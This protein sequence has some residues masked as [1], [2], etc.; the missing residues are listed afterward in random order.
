M[1]VSP[2]PSRDWAVE[3]HRGGQ[4]TEAMAAYRT[5]LARDPDSPDLLGLLGVATEQSGDL[6]EAERLL[7][8]SLRDR[9][10]IP[11]TFRNLNNLL[12]L[13]IE[14]ERLDDARILA[15]EH[16]PGA[17]PLDRQPDDIEQGTIVSLVSAFKDVGLA[18]EALAIGTPLLGLI[19]A[20]VDFAL[21]MAELLHEAGRKNEAAKLLDRDFGP[22]EDL[23]NLHAVRAAL[24][25]E[26]GDLAACELHSQR[27]TASMPTLLAKATPSQQFV[28]AVLNKAPELV[29]NFQDP[30]Q[31][32]YSGNYP[33]QLAQ[34]F[35]DHFRFVSILADSPTAA[36]SLRGLPRPALSLNNFTNAELLMVEDRLQRV[37]ALADGLGVKV[38]NHPRLAVQATR[39]KNSARF[40]NQP[41]IIFP[42]TERYRNDRAREGEVIADIEAR[43]DYPVIICTVFQQMGIGTWLAG[44]R[45]EL[46]EALYHVDGRQFY[47]IAYVPNQHRSG[48]YR[49]LRAAFIE[50]RPFIIRADYSDTW[51]VRAR[52]QLHQQ[53]FYRKYP[54]LLQH[55]NNIVSNPEMELGRSVLEALDRVAQLMPLEIFG[56][57]F[58]VTHNGDLLIFETNATMNL[59]ST[60][61]E[62]LEYPTEAEEGL[63]TSF[64]QYFARLAAQ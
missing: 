30:Y 3:L 54:D 2:S 58:D 5:L 25:H 32:H 18:D 61:P 24:A 44:N 22:G 53:G 13:L 28:L 4:I 29:Q 27:F 62:G 31:H 50:R 37:S 39:Q 26:R 14:A 11:L 21:L 48:A 10:S 45:Q 35:A 8:L 60:S 64:K 20:D 36:E 55:A 57:D 43:Y 46:A 6:G 40:A 52:R 1:P 34:T 41:G 15:R 42:A 17:W 63:R 16:L 12:G 49:S 9:T 47:A 7:R 59:L 33:T 56:M 51:N 19:G 38:I 23:P